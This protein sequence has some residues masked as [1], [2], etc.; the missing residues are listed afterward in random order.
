MP[1][2]VSQGVKSILPSSFLQLPTV[3]FLFMLTSIFPA[4]SAKAQQSSFD[5]EVGEISGTVLRASDKQPA[6]EVAVSLKSRV[7]GIFRSVLTD[8]E[9]RFKVQ[10]LPRGAYDVAVDEQGYEPTEIRTNLT[11]SSTKLVVY[12]KSN[13]GFI[14][15]SNFTVSVRELK[16]PSKA[17]NEYHEGLQRMARNDLAGS[18]Q[19]LTKATQAFPGY[20]E[21]FY[22][23][24]VVEATLKHD[25]QA[26]AAFQESI[27]LSG[28]R[29]A[30]PQFGFGYLLCQE[31]KPGEAEKIIRK[32]LD[33]DDR[34]PEGYVVLTDVL[35][36]LHRRDE[37]EASA[38]EALLRNP[39][40]PGTYLVLS[41]LDASKGDYPSELRDLDT[42]LKLRP[43]GPG[44]EQAR[45]MRQEI[46]KILAKS[47]PLD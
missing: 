26:K 23:I 10:N 4:P 37:A 34:S 47:Q 12:L 41:N 27:G 25:E 28:G 5:N 29:Y 38:R 46:Q 22:N 42:Y 16:I 7:A 17:K 20:F 18:L 3:I 40:F 9:G 31:G 45:E 33:V 8:V 32:G 15:Q 1:Y 19:H 39:K 2:I 36:Q 30:P 14:S 43:N 13:S 21:A 24:G 44:S 11:G 6:S 35:L